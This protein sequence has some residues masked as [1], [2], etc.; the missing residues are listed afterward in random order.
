MDTKTYRSYSARG[1][2]FVALLV[3]VIVAGLSC[4]ASAQ[5]DVNKSYRFAIGDEAHRI[6]SGDVWLY[7]YSWYGLQKLKL[8]TIENAV[9]T[10]RLDAEKVRREF[11]PHPNT[12]AYVVVLQLPENLWYRTPDI[13]PD[14]FWTNFAHVMDRLGQS[15]ALA[16]GETLVVLP[17][18]ARRRITLLHED[19]RPVANASVPVS[20]Y[21]YDTNH[22][23]FHTGLPL[24]MFTTNASGSFQ[25]LTPSVP[26]YLDSMIYYRKIGEGPAGAAFEEN[27]GLKT[28]VE[29][30]LV[31]QEAWVLRGQSDLPEQE[32]QLQILSPEGA[33]RPNIEIEATIRANTCGALNGSLGQTDA[34]GTAHI[35]VSPPAVAKLQLIGPDEKPRPLSDSELRELFLQKKLIVK[36]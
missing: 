36:W 10:I 17:T 4:S 33:P 12:D 35:K 9:A 11:D 32:L 29:D 13:S 21:L 3:A 7:S 23:A 25:V 20:I 8:A 1:S 19:G 18:P 27:I 16:A 31:I 22:C 28:G 5:Q 24:G 14:S 2:L 15:V 30:N 26:L 6:S 34:T